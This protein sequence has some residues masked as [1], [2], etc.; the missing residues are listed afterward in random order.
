[1]TFIEGIWQEV[2]NF[3]F[4]SWVGFWLYWIPLALCAVYFFIQ[5]AIDYWRDAAARSGNDGP[6][7]TATT[8]IYLPRLKIGTIVGRAIASICPVVNLWAAIFDAAPFFIGHVGTWL[9][10]MLDIP[11]IP[12]SETH[13]KLRDEKYKKGK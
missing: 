11:L 12:D 1:M 5:C 8:T 10:E 9:E 13:K 3:Q 4:T 7:K 6:N 2:I